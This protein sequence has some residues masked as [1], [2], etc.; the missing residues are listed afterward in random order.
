MSVCFWHLSSQIVGAAVVAPSKSHST[1]GW[2]TIIT[3]LLSEFMIVFLF[4]KHNVV[5]Y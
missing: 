3:V 4:G 5:E 1:R 2:I